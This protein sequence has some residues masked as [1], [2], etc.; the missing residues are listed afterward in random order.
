M[1]NKNQTYELKTIN[2]KPNVKYVDVLEEDK[3]I[4]GQKFACISFI[5]PEN[6][7]KNKEIFYFQEFLRGWEFAKSMEKFYEF[8]NF[9]AYKYKLAFNDVIN[10]FKEFLQEE[11]EKL[12]YSTLL[13]DYK[14]FIENNEE[15]LQ[16]EF[17]AQ[18]EFKTSVRGIKIRGVYGSKEEAEIRCK[19]LQEADP[20]H[21]IHIGE[22]GLWLPFDPS[23]LTNV[24]YMEE[25]LNQLMTEKNKN[26]SYAKS[27]FETRVKESKKKAI[28][29]NIK[30]AEKTGATLTQS[31]DE[32]GNLVSINNFNTQE[33]FLQSQNKE[34]TS[35]DITNELFEGE[36]IITKSNSQRN[37]LHIDNAGESA[38]VDTSFN[39]NMR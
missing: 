21:N 31:I 23:N 24:V 28:E 18:N 4:S 33:K 2:G 38:K 29:E 20:H 30:L 5:S 14:T 16:S 27:A 22:V 8:I 39:I 25:E 9:L 6:V 15:R 12:S 7:L 36:N 17:D 19:M 10:D 11:Q 34:I 3:P 35:K 32:E 26:E 37:P 13:D 1:A